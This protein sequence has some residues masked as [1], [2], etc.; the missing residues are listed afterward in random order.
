MD[1]QPILQKESQLFAKMPK[2]FKE[3]TYKGLSSD[4]KLLYTWGLDR[5]QLSKLNEWY[6]YTHNQEFIFYSVD[7]VMEDLGCASQKAVKIRK[8]LET[9]GLWEMID[10]GKNKPTK[11]FIKEIIPSQFSNNKGIRY[12]VKPQKEVKEV[13]PKEPA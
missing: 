4:A 6:D 13:E 7:Q 5:L 9:W 3:I 12:N 2:A 10:Q 1:N 8:E 11:I